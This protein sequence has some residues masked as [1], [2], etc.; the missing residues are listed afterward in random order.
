MIAGNV[1]TY[2]LWGCKY[3]YKFYIEKLLSAKSG[4]MKKPRTLKFCLWN[5]EKKNTLISVFSLI[6][7]QE[8][9]LLH[10]T[11][12]GAFTSY[13]RWIYSSLSLRHFLCY[14]SKWEIN[15]ISRLAKL[16]VP[17]IIPYMHLKYKYSKKVLI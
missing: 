7:G 13:V 11:D 12:L 9:A 16:N 6:P 5:K 4:N 15:F 10:D 8:Y 1:G 17:T 14:Y 3:N 2:I